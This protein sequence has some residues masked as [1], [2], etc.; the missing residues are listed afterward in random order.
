MKNKRLR[1]LGIEAAVFEDLWNQ[2]LWAMRNQAEWKWLKELIIR[3]YHA[4]IWHFL[5]FS[6]NIE[7]RRNKEKKTEALWIAASKL[8]YRRIIDCYT[9]TLPKSLIEMTHEKK[10]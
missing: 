9:T 7:S 5:A 4:S 1:P 6:I 2:L 10:T 3:N 8:G